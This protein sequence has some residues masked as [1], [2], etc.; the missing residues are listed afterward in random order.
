MQ[1]FIVCVV[2]MVLCAAPAF[3]DGDCPDRPASQQEQAAVQSV[4]SVVKTAIPAAPKDWILKDETDGRIGTTVPNC[5]DG[6]KDRPKYYRFV[7]KYHYS[8]EASDRADQAAVSTALKGTPEQQVRMAELDGKIG[9]LNERK[10]EARRSGTPEEKDQIK[11]ELK[12]AEKERSALTNEISDAYV[13]RA[14]S[15]SLAADMNKDKPAAKEA[16]V[17]IKVN[18]QRVWIPVQCA[19]EQI[20]GASHA[21]WCKEDRGGRLVILLGAWDIPQFKAKLANASIVTKAQN[22]AIEITA[23]QQMAETLAQQIKIDLLK[24]QL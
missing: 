1:L 24:K 7:F 11:E 13:K 2:F 23:D 15:G 10:K 19:P 21:Y 14:M 5:A 16:Q 8:S 4:Y 9:Q 3:A 18:E 6:P 20:P 17:I 22:M 12:A